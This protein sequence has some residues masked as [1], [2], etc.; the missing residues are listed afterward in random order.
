MRATSGHQTDIGKRSTR[1]RGANTFP[2]STRTGSP[3]RSALPDSSPISAVPSSFSDHHSPRSLR[4]GRNPSNPSS[5]K[6]TN[7]P[8]PITPDDLALPLRLR[9][10]LGERALEQE[11]EAGVVGVAL[12]LHR[13]ALGGRRRQPGLVE[14][15]RPRRD[16]VGTDRREQ[17]AVRD[18]VRVAPD[19]R[20]E[21]AVA[22]AREAGVAEVVRRV[23]RLLQRAQDERRERAAPAARAPDLLGDEPADLADRV[24]RLLR[25]HLLG[26]RRGGHV[27]RLELLHQELDPRRVRPL[28]D[29]VE[30]RQA[31]LGEQR[32]HLLVREDHQLLDQAC[33]TRSAS[34]WWTATTSPRSSN[35]N[36][37]SSDSTASE[38]RRARRSRSAA[39]TARA[40]ASALGPR[41]LGALL[42]REDPVHLRVVEPRVASDHAAVERRAHHALGLHLE[43]HRDRAPVLVR[44]EAAGLVRQRLR[45]HRLDRARDVDARAAPVGLGL[46]RRARPHV[47]GHVGDVDP[48]ADAAVLALGRDRV[49]EVAR[50][51]RVDRERG[52]RGEV[53]PVGRRPAACARPP[54]PRC[55]K[56][57][58]S[59]RS[60]MIASITSRATSGSPS[61]RITRGPRLPPPT[62]TIEPGRAPPR[63]LRRDRHPAAALEQRRGGQEPPAS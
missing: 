5:P 53:E 29:A 25:A 42:A 63:L 31:A 59:P 19:R 60:T 58:R 9:A 49:V 18:D 6:R 38:P 1:P 3:I 26:Q 40:A 14:L 46:E 28:V 12:D 16:V 22:L 43:L 54:R 10:A 57:R 45:Q 21:V 27:E 52:Q 4:A 11:R 50:R 13:L 15:G 30:G 51:H 23:V 17:R 32:R 24:R 36:C 8:A 41:L 35:S 61:G 37:G 62:S 39:A 2:T 56:L 47:G 7:A 20:R 48:E 44:H 33:A 55:G 34:R